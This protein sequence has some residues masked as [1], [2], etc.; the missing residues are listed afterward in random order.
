MK[1]YCVLWILS[2]TSSSNQQKRALSLPT[3]HISA[4]QVKGQTLHPCPAVPCQQRTVSA[5]I[6][7]MHGRKVTRPENPFYSSCKNI[8][9]RHT[10]IVLSREWQKEQKRRMVCYT[11]DTSTFSQFYSSVARLVGSKRFTRC[12]LVPV[13]VMS[14]KKDGSCAWP[15]PESHKIVKISDVERKSRGCTSH[16]N[17]FKDA[18][19]RL[20]SN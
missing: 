9:K 15:C 10:S 13:K 11:L 20:K 8:V 16:L 6:T 5:I 2:F 3:F 7:A 19:N 14:S 18:T 17:I 12:I 1:T 4:K